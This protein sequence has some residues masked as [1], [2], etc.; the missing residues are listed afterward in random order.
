MLLC[1]K[2]PTTYLFMR[3]LRAI[4]LADGRVWIL[5]GRHRLVD[6][7]AS[8]LITTEFYD[9]INFTRGPDMQEAKRSMCGFQDGDKTYLFGEFP[10][11]TG[12]TDKLF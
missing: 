1:T 9:G 5:G 8:D 10:E 7:S 12:N 6:S 11:C 3:Q 4:P 2:G